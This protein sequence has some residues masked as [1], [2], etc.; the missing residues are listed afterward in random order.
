MLVGVVSG[1]GSLSSGLIYA[2][3]GY[4]VISLLGGALILLAA[5]AG[6]WWS[7]SR[8]QPQAAPVD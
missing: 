6:A 3:L 2:A 4:R 7:L 1:V 8:R 5:F